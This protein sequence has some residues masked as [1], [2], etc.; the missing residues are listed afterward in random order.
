MLVNMRTRSH[1]GITVD[2]IN[3]SSEVA[4]I[5]K[6]A[7][8]FGYR[9]TQENYK[10]D[11]GAMFTAARLH[12]DEPD[13]LSSDLPRLVYIEAMTSGRSVVDVLQSVRVRLEDLH[14]EVDRP[15]S[16]VAGIGELHPDGHDD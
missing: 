10:T 9:L 3:G 2:C 7:A 8:K 6:A 13:W 1:V 11:H 4:E 15:P 5:A 16:D 12:R 14:A